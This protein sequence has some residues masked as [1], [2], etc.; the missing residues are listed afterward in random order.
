[1]ITYFKS[2]GDTSAP[3][4]R[5][6]NVAIDR[7][8]SGASKVICDQIRAEKDKTRRNEIKKKLPAIC[9]SGKFTS[10]LDTSITEHSGLICIDFD[11]FIDEWALLDARHKLTSDKHS[12][13]VFTSPS[14]D[15]LKVLVKIP[16]DIKNHKNYFLSLEQYYAMDEFDKTSK[17]IGRVCFES[18]DPEI[19]VNNDSALWDTLL[20]ESYQSFDSS[21]A[22]QTIKL[23]DS[24]EVI[25]RLKSWWNTNF[26]LVA[27]KRN[28]NTFILAS[29]LNEYG[30]SKA[31]A[32]IALSD[33]ESEGFPKNEIAL[34]IDSAYKNIEA[35]GTKFYE[36]TE[37]IDNIKQLVKQGVPEEQ[38]IESYGSMSQEVVKSVIS[39]IDDQEA[40]W[41]KNSKGVVKHVNHLYKKY[42]ETCGY[43]KYYIEGGKNFV[44]VNINNNT[45]SDATE[46]TIKDDV[47]EHLYGMEDLSI[48]NYFADKTKLFKEDH[49]SFLNSIQPSIMHDTA[50]EAHLYFRNCAVKVTKDNV[51]VI[52]YMSVSGYIWEKQKIDRDFVVADYDDCEFKRFIQN[53]SGNDTD[54]IRSIESTAGYLLHSYKPASYCPAVIINDEVISDNPE[55]GVGKGLY[56]HAI[57]QLKK[58]VIIDGKAFSF[59]KSFPYQR[60]SADTQM[61]VFDDVSRGFDF[62]R[63]F[64]VITEG[65]TLEKKNKDEIHI[66]FSRSPK[67]VISTNYA[68]KGAGNSFE[69]RKWEL[70][71]AQYYSKNYTPYDEFGHQLFTDWD[72]AQW[73]SFDNY[74]IANLQLYLRKGLQKSKFKNLKERKFIA[75][76][77]MDFYDWA[78]DRYNDKTKVGVEVLGQDLYN[79]F[80]ELYPDYGPRGKYTIARNKF[81]NWINLYGDFM[82]NRHPEKYR[83]TLGVTFRFERDVEKQLDLNF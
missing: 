42:L 59:Q 35:H 62:E 13:C 5:E 27:G 20:V 79:G 76:T 2:L 80:T 48:Y 25:R 10:R 26:G 71:F 3:F 53:V 73:H 49:L 82:Y 45:I 30:I 33:F 6:V 32:S 40:F 22:R 55:G 21:T 50:D 16:K 60:V 47:L 70:E 77:S 78:R 28:N 4:F 56:I 61:L 23:N 67:I 74:M 1:M 14:G 72:D 83:S 66:P 57:S 63:L 81:Y 41:T 17:N 54:R 34:I 75:E 52:D 46:D 15:G 43:A 12:F 37:K 9:F 31:D 11:G 24:N 39:S 38:V 8:R 36:D 64:S 51:E 19:Y 44:F 58:S 18:Y 65:I 7:I 29:A 68:I 69:R